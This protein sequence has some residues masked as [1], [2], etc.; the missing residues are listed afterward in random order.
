MLAAEVFGQAPRP[1]SRPAG[2]RPAAYADRPP[3]DL[4]AVARGKALYGVHCNFCHGS[5]ARG[6]EGGPNLLRIE[7]VLNDQKG[8]LIAPVVQSGRGEMPRINLTG[9][10][11]SD[12]AAFVHSFRVSGSDMSR[13]V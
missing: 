12:I 6:G 2:S 13:T 5:D 11:I 10:Q 3:A 8:E 4:A 1:S 7:T 9:E